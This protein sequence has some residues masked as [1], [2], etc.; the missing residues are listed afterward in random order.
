M[1][2]I[3]IEEAEKDPTLCARPMAHDHNIEACHKSEQLDHLLSPCEELHGEASGDLESIPETR[4][5]TAILET[6]ILEKSAAFLK[7]LPLIHPMCLALL[8]ATR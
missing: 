1:L 4:T 5:R 3:R 7:L 8:A 6:A 2:I